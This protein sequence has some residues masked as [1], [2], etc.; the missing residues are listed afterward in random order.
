MGAGSKCSRD[1]A[2][3][4]LPFYYPMVSWSF[5][6]YRLGGSHIARRRSAT[7]AMY[8]DPIDTPVSELPALVEVAEIGRAHV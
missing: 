7:N 8:T 5:K 2:L 3:T 6:G 1:T 4:S